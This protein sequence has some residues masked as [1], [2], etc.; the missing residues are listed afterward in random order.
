MWIQA[1]VFWA[2]IYSHMH[3]HISSHSP[4]NHYD[5]FCWWVYL[6]DFHLTDC[7]HCFSEFRKEFVVS[8]LQATVSCP[9]YEK[10]QMFETLKSSLKDLVLFLLSILQNYPT[11]P[12][13]RLLSLLNSLLNSLRKSQFHKGLRVKNVYTNINLSDFRI[14]NPAVRKWI[15]IGDDKKLCSVFQHLSS[16][17]LCAAPSLDWVQTNVLTDSLHVILNNLSSNNFTIKLTSLDW[18]SSN[19]E[20]F[21]RGRTD[22]KWN[23]QNE[24]LLQQLKTVPSDSSTS[25]YSSLWHSHTPYMDCS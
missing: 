16:K 17:E 4:L 12:S 18:E 11:C 13:W 14:D 22:S 8:V 3:S 9:V 15:C 23:E 10:K 5:F 2:W 6:F 20:E 21:I 25:P 1:H 7:F 24:Q 19:D